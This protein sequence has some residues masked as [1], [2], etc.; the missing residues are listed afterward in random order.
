[1]LLIWVIE[2]VLGCSNQDVYR[3]DAYNIVLQNKAYYD[4]MKYMNISIYI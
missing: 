1:M 4:I 2:T 3:K